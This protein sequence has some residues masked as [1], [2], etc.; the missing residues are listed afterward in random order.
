MLP[1]RG[2]YLALLTI[3]AA[4]TSAAQ[5]PSVAF[6]TYDPGFGFSGIAP[7]P[8]GAVWFSGGSMI[9]RITSA[10][11][12]TK[13]AVSA[14]AYSITPGS[15]G[16][17]WFTEPKAHQIGRITITGAITEYP[18]PC[19]GEPYSIVAG[20]DGAL[21]F[22]EGVATKIGRITTS[23]T[24]TEYPIPHVAAEI[25]AGPDGALWF[26]EGT[27]DPDACEGNDWIGR[28]TTS[29]LVTEYLVAVCGGRLG[30]SIVAGP[31]GALWF[32]E[33]FYNYAIG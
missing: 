2:L 21:W 23:G 6:T 14:S 27:N 31:D 25:V 30:P 3:V 28:I 16:A 17:L 29:G 7:G 10:G 4:A 18:I 9:G 13:Y 1:T 15:D 22:S 19:C 20:P 26:T 5:A 12:I 11:I 32:D 8:D 24:V 33:N